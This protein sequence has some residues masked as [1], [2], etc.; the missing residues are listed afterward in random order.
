MSETSHVAIDLAASTFRRASGK[1][2][3]RAGEEEGNERN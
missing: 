2:G 1:A 3:L